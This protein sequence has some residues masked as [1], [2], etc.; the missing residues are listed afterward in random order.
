MDTSQK[1][2]TTPE[3]AL[4]AITRTALGVG[5]GLLLA[6][7]LNDQARVAVGLAMLMIGVATTIPLAM[8]V[9][10]GEVP[11]KANGTE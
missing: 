6:R 10:G 11:S 1:S 2:V 8:E 3:V 4:I 9:F 7:R 5:I